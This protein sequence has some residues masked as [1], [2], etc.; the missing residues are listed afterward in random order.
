MDGSVPIDSCSLK[1]V[2][3]LHEVRVLFRVNCW[4][5]CFCIMMLIIRAFNVVVGVL[6]HHRVKL[7][8]VVWL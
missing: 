5:H 6:H 8:R 2:S 4:V 3:L 7:M 1:E